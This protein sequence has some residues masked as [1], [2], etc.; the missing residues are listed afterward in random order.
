MNAESPMYTLGEK[1]LLAKRNLHAFLLVC[2][3]GFH[4]FY[5]HQVKT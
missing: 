1:E 5:I 2:F 3:R 4:V